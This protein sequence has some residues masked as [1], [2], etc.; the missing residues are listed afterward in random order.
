MLTK[1]QTLNLSLHCKQDVRAA[2]SDEVQVGVRGGVHADFLLKRAW[3]QHL[4][5]R[6][7][8]GPSPNTSAYPVPD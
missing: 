4:I 6:Q 5:F 8:P 7:V 1:R 2:G 3:S